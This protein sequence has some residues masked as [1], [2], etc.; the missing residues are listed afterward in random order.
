MK[1][2]TIFLFGLA[3]LGCNPDYL[4]LKRDKSQ[5]VPTTLDDFD[6]LLGNASVMNTGSGHAL[7]MISSD[8]YNTTDN[9]VNL[10]SRDFERNAFLWS[11]DI[12]GD[13]SSDDWN[14]GYQR[15]LYCNI[16]LEGLQKLQVMQSDQ[17]RFDRIKGEALFQRALSFYNLAIQF[18]AL[19][20][21]KE[22]AQYGI[23]LRTLSDPE[24]IA[25]R[26][27]A[28]ETYN[29]IVSDLLAAEVLLPQ[30]GLSIFRGSKVAAQV[31]LSRVYLLMADYVKS[32]VY[33]K[34]AIQSDFKLLDYNGLDI[35]SDVYFAS[36]GIGNT[37]VVFYD[38]PNYAELLFETNAFISD[39]TYFLFDEADLRRKVFFK[40]SMDDKI[41]FKGSYAGKLDNFTGLSIDEVYLT[42]AEC[43]IRQDNVGEGMQ[44]LKQL[45]VRRYKRGSDISF[46]NLDE[47]EAL[48]L[49]LQERKKELLFRGTRWMDLRRL[50]RE[51]HTEIQLS[52]KYMGKEYVLKPNDIRY[53][54]PIA[55]DVL[56]NSKVI[57]IP[58]LEVKGLV[59]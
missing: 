50:N 20:G 3:I 37:E 29:R 14:T 25:S 26:S 15:I 23:P 28:S 1:R 34:N 39:E 6:G 35:N 52:R 13:Q 17:S 18:A 42:L 47:K 58:R 38:S 44:Y 57:Q 54:F 11:A 7:A 51:K 24:Q 9:A 4:D 19:P 36:Y 41:V 59:N 43:L 8:E 46:A 10:A 48:Q 45:L 40:K 30:K 33:A 32:A 22:Y 55:K 21:N 5:T 56:L 12:F 16:I 27:S 53:I 2:L 31:L 49:I